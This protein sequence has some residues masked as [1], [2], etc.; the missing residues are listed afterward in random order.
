MTR[1]SYAQRVRTFGVAGNRR[2]TV[3]VRTPWGIDA[4]CHRLVAERFMLACDEAKIRSPWRPLRIDSFNNRPIR[5]ALSPS[6]HSWALAWD[7]FSTPP[8]VVPPGG[9]WHPVD[10]VPPDFAAA[11]TARGFTWG[12]TFS[13]RADYPHIEWAG[14]VPAPIPP[15]IPP[16]PPAVHGRKKRM[17]LV[18][19]PTGVYV[20]FGK[21]PDGS[22]N[23][24]P[25]SGT[26]DRDRIMANGVPLIEVTAA[27]WRNDWGGR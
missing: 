21:H 8:G 14:G 20:Y 13:R 7:F 22:A 16:Q 12:A 4:V 9:V 25:L 24:S 6:L 19:V 15:V 17:L 23:C 2:N 11:F 26:D 18:Q 5:N 3:T 27:E 10:A 1:I